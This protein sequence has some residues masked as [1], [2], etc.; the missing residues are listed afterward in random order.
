MRLGRESQ[1]FLAGQGATGEAGDRPRAVRAVPGGRGAPPRPPPVSP[2]PPGGGDGR[3]EGDSHRRGVGGINHGRREAATTGNQP[4]ADLTPPQ[5]SSWGVR[6]SENYTR[7]L[8][9]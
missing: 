6:A 7:F 1:G 8:Q 9:R 3:G 4:F 2:S 5:F